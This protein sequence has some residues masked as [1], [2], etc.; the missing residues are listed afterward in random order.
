MLPLTLVCLLAAADP[1]DPTARGQAFVA[2][3]GR[4]DFAAAAADFDAAMQKVLPADKLKA[5]GVKVVENVDKTGFVKD[6]KPIQ[7][8]LAK[9]LGP[10]AVKI[11]LLIRETK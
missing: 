7:D 11:L 6:A 3:L 10:H 8:Q 5:M 1:A 4:G 2:A 9:E